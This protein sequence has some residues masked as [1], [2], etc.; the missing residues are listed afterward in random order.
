MTSLVHPF[1]AKSLIYNVPADIKEDQLL[2][3]LSSLNV[4]FVKRFTFKSIT[5]ETQLNTTVFLHCTDLPSLVKIGYMLFNPK[6]FIP[7]PLR[8]FKCHAFGHVT[9]VCK[10]K[11]KCA[12][13][14]GTHNIKNCIDNLL[15]VG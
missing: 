2:N 14:D 4:K 6:M 9:K 7:K 5:N 12:K 1:G 3:C 13:C 11:E 8:C 15:I 10:I